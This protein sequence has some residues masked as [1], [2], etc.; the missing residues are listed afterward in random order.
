MFPL[1]KDGKLGFQMLYSKHNVVTQSDLNYIPLYEECIDLLRDATIF[2]TPDGNNGYWQMEIPKGDIEETA[3]GS[4]NGLLQFIYMPF[5]LKSAVGTFQC[6]V[7]VILL[8]VQRPFAMIYQENIGIIYNSL[9][10]HIKHLRL[11]LTLLV[12]QFNFC[13]WR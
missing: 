11:D 7:E 12:G 6:A 3:F 9:E 10:A 2:S 1:K 5:R 4:T 13:T 8:T